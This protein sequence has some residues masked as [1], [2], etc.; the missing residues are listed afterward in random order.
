MEPNEQNTEKNSKVYLGT[1]FYS[2]R[3]EGAMVVDKSWKY[4]RHIID[5]K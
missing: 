4:W 1:V 3:V 2:Y 5:L